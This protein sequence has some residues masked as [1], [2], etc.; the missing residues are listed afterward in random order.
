[1]IKKG[2]IPILFFI[3]FSCLF[4]YS[5]SAKRKVRKADQAFYEYKYDKARKMYSKVLRKVKDKDEKERVRWQ[6]AESYRYKDDLEN[7]QIAYQ[8]LIQSKYY[9]KEP[10]V[11]YH[12]GNIL[13][14]RS[15][16]DR[17]LTAFEKY[18][19]L[20]PEDTLGTMAL[21]R[22]SLAREY[23]ID[24][25]Q[26]E[27]EVEKKLNSDLDDWAPTYSNSALNEIIFT[28]NKNS[29]IGKNR[30][31]W[32]GKKFSDL[33]I[34]RKDLKG[35]WGDPKLLEESEV[36]NTALN[37]G[38]PAMNGHFTTLYFT[39]CEKPEGREGGCAVYASKRT[40]MVWGAP[41]R[42]DM[43]EDSS[44]VIGH[45]TVTPDESM[46]IVSAQLP[47]G[48]GGKDLFYA[49]GSG[50]TFGEL[51]NLGDVLNT[52]GNEMFPYLR[53]DSVLY[54]SSDFHPGMGG[55]DIFKSNITYD[56]DGEPVFSEP[57]NMRYPINSIGD[58]LGICFHP[59]GNEE[60]YFSS[61]RKYSSGLDIYHFIIEPVIFTISGVIR[62]MNTLLYVPDVSIT[63]VGSDSTAIEIKTGESGSYTFPKTQVNPNTDYVIIVEKEGYFSV[64]EKIST[65]GLE[66]SKNF[67]VD[68]LNFQPVPK[69]PVVLPEIL[70]DYAKW[71]LKM[72]YQDSLRGLIQILEANPTVA[73]EL[74]AH[75]DSRGSE[76][77][78]RELSQKRAQ[79]VVDYLIDRGIDGDRL[80]A[81]G[82][83]KT[84][85]RV[86][87]NDMV[88]DG[89]TFPAKTQLNDEYIATLSSRIHQEAAH[90]LNR[91]IEFI[92]TSTRYVPKQKSDRTK[93]AVTVAS[94]NDRNGIPITLIGRKEL[95]QME[96]FINGMSELI[97]ID[98][99]QRNAVVSLEV[100]LALLRDGYITK[101]DFEGDPEKVLVGGTIAK[102]ARF[103]VNDLK[104]GEK[105]TY[106]ITVIVDHNYKLPLTVP[107]SV[108]RDMGNFTID[109]EKRLLFFE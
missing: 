33:Y 69:D 61:N 66:T 28:S 27:V 39:R 91:R 24:P 76:E 3:L 64:E 44:A 62:D 73:I 70:F 97:I 67:K 79:S 109:K 43:V 50:G 99:S 16:L 58:D 52:S 4:L 88:R 105:S 48:R 14:K 100:A 36:I 101:D 41:Q 12:L 89:F 65:V 104:I 6:I 42:L 87:Q 96:G 49:L 13:L 82:Y 68:V 102:N 81:R 92:I 20:A 5:C 57:V 60:G 34:V 55:L 22:V 98:E 46:I 93:P 19:E 25:G 15:R 7:G 59:E 18:V 31:E 83:G 9:E 90:Q 32:T 23:E 106:D 75:T 85:P 1:M 107:T 74:G 30:D 86:L 71:D 108:V 103:M 63:L 95:P 54:F 80:T 37:E 2:H 21:Q 26:Y 56:D 11:Y 78:N 17:S 40:G 10:L 45:P 47:G 29:S 38:T 72:Q 35:R 77:A 51:Q 94:A 8:N 53:G 84:A